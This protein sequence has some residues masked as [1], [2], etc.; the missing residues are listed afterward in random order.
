MT[1]AC[2]AE[3]E[4]IISRQAQVGDTSL[5]FGVGEREQEFGAA[6][7]VNV[8]VAVATRDNTMHTVG[9]HR[10]RFHLYNTQPSVGLTIISPPYGKPF[11][12][13]IR[14]CRYLQLIADISN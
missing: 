10:Y 9:R 12:H 2:S 6:Q 14:I 5:A 1:D 7:I 3:Y 11:S 8:N 4:P 13:L